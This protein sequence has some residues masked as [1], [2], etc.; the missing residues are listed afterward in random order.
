MATASTGGMLADIYNEE[1]YPL[2]SLSSIESVSF[3]TASGGHVYDV[4]GVSRLTTDGI[5]TTTI[6]TPTGHSIAVTE[7]SCMLVYPEKNQEA[8]FERRLKAE[9]KEP[10]VEVIYTTHHN[11]RRLQAGDEAGMTMSTTM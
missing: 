6:L 10:K 1:K 7:N 2:P 3:K 11:G 4:V 9:N 5:T 8:V